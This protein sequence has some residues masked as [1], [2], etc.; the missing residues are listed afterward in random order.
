MPEILTAQRLHQLLKANFRAKNDFNP[1]DYVCKIK[2][3]D[4]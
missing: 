2:V 4:F 1:S 3:K